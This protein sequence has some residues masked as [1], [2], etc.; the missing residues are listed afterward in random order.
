MELALRVSVPALL[1]L[2]V[3]EQ[4]LV[5]QHLA[6]PAQGVSVRAP[7]ASLVPAALPFPEEFLVH[8]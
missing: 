8:Q 1:A 2:P 5:A 4:F 3:R 6:E 7:V